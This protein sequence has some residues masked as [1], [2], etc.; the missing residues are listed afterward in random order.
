[1][2]NA[3]IQGIHERNLLNFMIALYQTTVRDMMA[4]LGR[5]PQGG[6]GGGGGGGEV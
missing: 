1:M 6:G 3:L 2:R 4:I 5:R